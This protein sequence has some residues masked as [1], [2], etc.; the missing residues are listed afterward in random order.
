MT[1]CVNSGT[2]L[3]DI[4]LDFLLQEDSKYSTLCLLCSFF[5]QKKKK[6]HL[7]NRFMGFIPKSQLALQHVKKE[8]K[9]F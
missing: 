5:T 7:K 6:E 3:Y 4:F 2:F 8:T 9:S 1:C